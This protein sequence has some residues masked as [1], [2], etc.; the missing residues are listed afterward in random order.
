MFFIIFV[1][2]WFFVGVN[3]FMC[4]KVF[5]LSKFFG[6]EFV[7]KWFFVGVDLYVNLK[8]RKCSI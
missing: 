7:L 8:I 2:I 6:V 5:G 4:S 1:F 3:L